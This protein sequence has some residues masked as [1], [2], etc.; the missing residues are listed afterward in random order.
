MPGSLTITPMKKNARTSR[1]IRGGKRYKATTT[2]VVSTRPRRAA[3]LGFYASLGSI[4]GTFPPTLTTWHKWSTTFNRITTTTMSNYFISAN[5]LNKPDLTG[6]LTKQPL[7]ATNLGQVYDHYQVL[8]STCRVTAVPLSLGQAPANVCLWLNDDAT[9]V[10]GNI[11][12]V[13][14][15]TNSK[16]SVKTVCAGATSPVVVYCSYD[17]AR[18][19]G[20]GNRGNDGLQGGNIASAT[21][22]TESSVFTISQESIQTN[23]SSIYY[24]IEVVYKTL[25]YELKDVII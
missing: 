2:T 23:S 25:W 14:D 1:L 18:E 3:R 5:G 13:L 16:A 21:N 7:Y 9:V 6:T 20:P 22:P 17:A 15:N 12:Q 19:Y 4:K 10:P 24:T 8:S 11:F